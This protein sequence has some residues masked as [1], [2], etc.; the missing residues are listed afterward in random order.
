MIAALDV[1]HRKVQKL[2]GCPIPRFPVR[3]GGVNKLHAAFLKRKPHKRPW[4]VP[5]SGKFGVLDGVFSGKGGIP[6]ISTR[7]VLQSSLP[8]TLPGVHGN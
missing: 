5:R 8:A 4:L 3:P 6:R 2:F 7:T 1:P